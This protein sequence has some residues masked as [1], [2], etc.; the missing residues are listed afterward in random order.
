MRLIRTPKITIDQ[1]IKEQEILQRYVDHK[2]RIM[3]VSKIRDET[4]EWKIQTARQ[5]SFKN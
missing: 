5:E 4:K 1:E 3:N 2:R